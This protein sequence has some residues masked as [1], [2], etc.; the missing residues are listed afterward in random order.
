MKRNDRMGLAATAILA[1][2]CMGAG[3][4]L[5]VKILNLTANG[6]R[7]EA[8]VVDMERGAKNSKWPV[9]EFTTEKGIEVRARDLTQ[10]MF[11]PVELGDTVSVLYDP[12]DPS[13]AAAELGLWMWRGPVVFFSGSVFLVALGAAIWLH[14]RRHD[15]DQL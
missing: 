8:R 7:T 2:A 5:L 6:L 10:R 14:G 1:I 12:A 9:Y 3:T 13:R 15:Q 11:A 4:F